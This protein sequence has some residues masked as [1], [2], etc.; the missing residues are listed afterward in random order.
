MSSGSFSRYEEVSLSNN[1][2][3]T[4]QGSG[5]IMLYGPASIYTSD[6]KEIYYYNSINWSSVL[7]P[8][9][10]GNIIK[11]PNDYYTSKFKIWYI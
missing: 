9:F 4:L 7:I 2:S 10:S 1:A 8:F 11:N 5:F 6:N 3:E